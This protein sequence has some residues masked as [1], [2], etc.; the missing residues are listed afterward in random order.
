MFTFLIYLELAIVIVGMV[1]V[2]AKTRDVFHPLFLILPTFG[3][4]YGLMPFNLDDGRTLG[5]YFTPDQLVFVQS[6]NCAGTLAFVLGGAMAGTSVVRPRWRPRAPSVEFTQIL[7]NAATVMGVIALTAWTIGLVNVGG[8]T[9]AFSK[10]YAGGWDSSGYIRDITI[11]M[12]GAIVL[13]LLASTFSA[14]QLYQKFLLVIFASPWLVQAVLTAR[15]GPTFMITVILAMSF[16]LN[17]NRRPS[18]V[19]VLGAG[20]LFGYVILFLV[21]NRSSLHLGTDFTEVNTD[22]AHI[23]AAD[24]TGNEYIYGSGSIVAADKSGRH[25]WG[26]R[27]AAQLLVRPIPSAIWTNKYEDFGIPEVLVNAGTGE[28]F[29]DN[30]GWEGAVGSAPGIIADMWVEGR[31]FVLPG[32]FALG[33]TYAR[34]WRRAIQIRGPWISQYIIAVSLSLYLVMQTMEAVIFRFLLLSIP[35]WIAWKWAKY[36]GVPYYVPVFDVTARQ[37][38]ARGPQTVEEHA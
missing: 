20:V 10:A 8:F 25:F 2:Y 16:Y 21:V 32:L 18:L 24:D 12:L 1:Y 23:V 19:K 33:W 9:N 3:F 35:L 26:R 30:L 22:V 11:W 14:L 13:I 38:G 37:A 17:R 29:L 34:L 28:G 4:I 6:L 31:W 36:V 7:V 27:Y 15:R 5:K